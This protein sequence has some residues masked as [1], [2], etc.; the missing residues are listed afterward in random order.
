MRDCIEL[1]VGCNTAA[2]QRAG[3]HGNAHRSL[4]LLTASALPARPD[5]YADH[6]GRES[7]DVSFDDDELFGIVSEALPSP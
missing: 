2:W 5:G 3:L 7:L 6:G 4:S 1:L